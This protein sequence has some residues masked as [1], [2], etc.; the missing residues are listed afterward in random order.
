MS[1]YRIRI[2]ALDPS[3]ELR[4]EYRIGIECDGFTIIGDKEDGANYSIHKMSTVD[5]AE[6]MVNSE[7]LLSAAIIAKAMAEAKRMEREMKAGKV[8]EAFTAR[9]GGRDGD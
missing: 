6:A 1:K 8:L 5:I 3:E 7:D 9:I 2:E 4:A